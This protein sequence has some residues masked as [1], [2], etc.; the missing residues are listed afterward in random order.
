MVRDI[1]VLGLIVVSFLVGVCGGL[2]FYH[3][4]ILRLPWPW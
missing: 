2:L 1:D 4:V 3:L